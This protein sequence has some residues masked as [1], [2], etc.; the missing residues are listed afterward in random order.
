M[1]R[2]ERDYD[3][4][5]GSRGR[6]QG[7][8]GGM[9]PGGYGGNW[10]G[11]QGEG[12]GR[13]EDYDNMYGGGSHDRGFR[14]GSEGGGWRG[15]QGGGDFRGEDPG[16]SRGGGDFGGGYG[17]ERGG[18][19]ARAG[20]YGG[21]GYGGGGYGGGGY[22]EGGYGGRGWDSGYGGRE[23][24]YD[25]GWQ[26]GSGGQRRTSTRAAEIMTE[27]PQTVTPDT[28]LSEVAKKMRDLDVGIIP[29]VDSQE[30]RRLRG[31]ITDRDIAVRAVAEGKD[32]NA[33][34]SDCMTGE[35]RSVNKNDSVNDVMRIMRDEQVRRVPVTDR[36][37]RLVGIIAQADVAVDWGGQGRDRG[38]EVSTTLKRISQPAEPQRGGRMAASGRGQQQGRGGSQQSSED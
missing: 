35:V 21:G 6:G 22:G 2:Y 31:V 27:N 14:G 13:D 10:A 34:V 20:G 33:K 28:T 15:G 5:H 4:E 19:S 12:Y 3:S 38:E 9:R 37:G 1:A 8:S 24:G 11:S 17:G 18:S 7:R 36:E 23:S 29:I 32:G 26:G 30:N 16:G 25:E